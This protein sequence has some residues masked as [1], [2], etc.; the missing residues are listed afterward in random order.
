MILKS[1]LRLLSFFLIVRIF[2]AFASVGWYV[3]DE[4]WQSVEIAHGI[5]WPGKKASIFV[6]EGFSRSK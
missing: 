3:P 6:L 5:V 1:K 4:T 2:M